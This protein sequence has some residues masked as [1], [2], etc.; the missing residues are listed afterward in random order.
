LRTTRLAGPAALAV[1]AAVAAALYWHLPRNGDIWWPDASRHALNGAF[2]LDFLHAMPVRHPTEWALDYYRQWPA[3]TIL[4]YPPLY[5]LE[6]AGSY[7]LFGVSEASALALGFVYV[8]ALGAGAYRLS[9]N[10]LSPA[11]ALAVALLTIGS[12]EVLFWAQQVMLDVPA[13]ALIVWSAAL[14]MDWSRRGGTGALVASAACAALAAH[15]KYNAIFFVLPLV[16]GVVAARGWR[17]LVGRPALW[18]AGVGIVLLLPL[19]AVFFAFASFNLGQ[20]AFVPEEIGPRF[21]FASLTYYASIMPDIVGWPALALALACGALALVSPNF[22]LP[23]QDMAFLLAWLAI[24]YAFCTMIAVKQPRHIVFIAYP[25]A[26]AAVLAI[27]RAMRFR[28][29]RGALALALAAGVLWFSAQGR[30]P[31]FVSG[32]KQAAMEVARVAPPET[33]VAF[34]GRLD[35]TFIFDLRA[36]G[37]RPDLGVVRLDKFLLSGAT[38]AL[39]WGFTEEKFSADQIADNLAKLHVQYVVVQPEYR[40]DLTVVKHLNEAMQSQRFTLVATIPMR[41]NDRFALA[42]RLLIYRAVADVPMGRVAP[43]MEIGI[44]GRKL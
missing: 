8:F 15:T 13:Y 10:W 37:E 25:L 12:P 41:S 2:V 22:R 43:S 4:F 39:E 7:A 24:G 31:P 27:D 11:P 17:G 28:P 34:W 36:Y 38:V 30:P 19:V 32:L 14:F 40:D 29:A 42:T 26:L 9:R 44:L 20:A 5:Y 3:L 16:V 23:R 21:G 35:G 1:L 6:L 18:A 33:N